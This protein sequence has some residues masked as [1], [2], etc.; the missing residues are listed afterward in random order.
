MQAEGEFH[1]MTR[2]FIVEQSSLEPGGHYYGYTC[3]I[4]EG[5]RQAGLDPVILGNER[6]KD[7]AAKQKFEVVPTFTHTWAEAEL[8]GTLDWGPGNIAYETSEAFRRLSPAPGDHVLLHTLGYHELRVLL[9]WLTS[10]LPGDLMPYF[11]ILH[12]AGGLALPAAQ[13]PAARRHRA[14]VGGIRQDLRRAVR[15]RADPV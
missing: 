10:K 7:S 2:L 12:I 1:R 14:V 4:A 3:C 5:A 9:A 8:E 13:D 6:F 15:H 11:H